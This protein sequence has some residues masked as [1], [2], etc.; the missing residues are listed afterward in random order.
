MPHETGFKNVVP[1]PHDH[2]AIDGDRLDRGVGENES[3]SDVLGNLQSG[4]QGGEIV[5]ISTEPM[6][7]DD[8]VGRVGS[9]F[10]FNGV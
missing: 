9:G 8:T 1:R 10:D 4:H 5:A 7:P 2:A 3:N 6:Q